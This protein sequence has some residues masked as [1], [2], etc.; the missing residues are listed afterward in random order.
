MK[1]WIRRYIKS[2]H[3]RC[4]VNK[5]VLQNFAKF[6]RKHLCWRLFLIKKESNTVVFLWTLRN[7]E[8]HL[9]QRK[10]ESDRFWLHKHLSNVQCKLSIFWIMFDQ[11]INLKVIAS[12]AQKICWGILNVIWTKAAAIGVLWKKVFL[13]ILLNSQENT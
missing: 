6:T 13:E 9:F 3:W 5:G 8:E 10:T 11:A 12:T 2:S 1:F 7:F 4:S